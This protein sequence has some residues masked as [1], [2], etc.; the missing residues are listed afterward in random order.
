MG[1]YTA[2]YIRVSTDAQFEEGYSVDAQKEML[3]AFCVAKKIQ[4]YEFYIDGGFTG[5]NIN[6]PEMQRMI[7]DIKTGAVGGVLVYKLDR[8]SRSQKDTLYLIEDVFNTHD[9]T[10]TSLN[11]NFDTSTPM[12]KAMLGIMSVFAQLERETIRERTRMGMLERVKEGLWMGGA[13]TPFGYDYDTAQNTLIPNEDS[14]KVRQCF[15]MITQGYSADAVA[16][17]LGFKYD[18]TV[19]N[20]ISRKTYLGLIEYNGKTYQGKHQPIID[21][22]LFNRVQGIV[23]SRS[24][25]PL[26]KTN[27]LL[28]GLLECGKCGAKMRYMKWGNKG[29]KL[30]CYSQFKS[31]PYLIKDPNCDAEK[32]WSDDIEE[33]VINAIKLRSMERSDNAK[34]V[35]SPL[36]ALRKQLQSEK[37]K[38]KRLY[39]LYSDGDD[40]LLDVIEN[41]K[42]TINSLSVQI[43]N[44]EY[45][46]AND[47]RMLSLHEKLRGVTKIWD[48]LPPTQRREI[49]LELLNKVVVNGAEISV[50]FK[51]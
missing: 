9:V 42:R 31:K 4:D 33:E 7:K 5:S 45:K 40:S 29:T 14:G 24:V 3:Q 43:S 44:A 8:L 2:I 15:E 51:E 11:E 22:E 18:N 20:I 26:H 17:M 21:E 47:E 46:I 38:L 16:E 13:R 23:E 25:T 12:G 39:E 28:T 50:Y 49:V 36:D 41:K 48:D 10:F 19:R 30:V 6:R 27:Y 35:A 37:T 1:K 32:Y 34:E